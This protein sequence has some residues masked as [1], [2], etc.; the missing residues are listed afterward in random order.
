[1]SLFVCCVLATHHDFFWTIQWSVAAPDGY[2]RPVIVVKPSNALPSSSSYDDISRTFFGGPTIYVHQYDTLDV[3]ITNRLSDRVI[4]IHWHGLH[5]QDNVAMDGVPGI[6]QSGILP[7]HSFVY[8]LNITQPPGTHFYH[9]HSGLQSSDGFQ[10]LFVIFDPQQPQEEEAALT[11]KNDK[12]EYVVA[13]QDWHHE[14]SSTLLAKYISRNDAYEG[15]KPDYPYPAVSVLIN[16]KGQFN[17]SNIVSEQDCELVRKWGWPFLISGKN[18]SM[19]MTEKQEI[20]QTNGQCNPSREPFVGACATTDSFSQFECTTGQ[21]LTLRLVGTGFSLGLRFWIDGHNLTVIAKDGTPIQPVLENQEAVF[22]HA[23]ERLDVL[24]KCDQTPQNYF[25]FAAVAYE[26]YGK[27]AHLKSPNVSSYAVLHYDGANNSGGLPNEALCDPTKWPQPLLN[28]VFFYASQYESGPAQKQ[29][30]IWSQSKGHWWNYETNTSGKRLEWWELNEH[31]PLMFTNTSSLIE[32][33]AQGTANVSS[34]F[35]GL[36][37]NLVYNQTY[38]FVL[39]NNESQPHPWHVHGYTVDVL[40]VGSIQRM[41]ELLVDW[42][43]TVPNVMRADTFITPAKGFV[44]FR[45]LANNP[46]PWLVHC[47]MPYHA[48]VGMVFLLS[49]EYEGKQCAYQKPQQIDIAYWRDVRP[50]TVIAFVIAVFVLAP[51]AFAMSVLFLGRCVVKWRRQ[52]QTL[53]DA[54]VQAVPLV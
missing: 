15:F 36:L 46:G 5:Q 28:P 37:F 51:I 29:F 4:S 33:C 1:M 10:G 49:V 41:Q 47:H 14:L 20:W 8:R 50:T 39:V 53:N 32:A 45:I 3:H 54:Y 13:L 30:L 25:V 22:L 31:T 34:L 35:S 43:T 40:R 9:S 16:G 18:S 38:D 27:T 24:V 26:Y 2:P 19:R 11:M 44:Q 12:E 17:C 52:R 48:E 7:M 6:T 42:N 23:G 21:T